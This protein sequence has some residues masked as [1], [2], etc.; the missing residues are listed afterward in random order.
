[1]NVQRSLLPGCI[2]VTYMYF[3][4]MDFFPSNTQENSSQLIEES[5]PYLLFEK[6]ATYFDRDYVPERAHRLLRDAKLVSII[7]SPAKRAYS[8]YQH[9]IAH[10]DPT[11]SKHS[12]YEIITAKP[13][14]PKNIRNLQA[15]YVNQTVPYFDS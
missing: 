5:S 9:M 11:A 4:Y 12:F 14:A 3:R 1:M 6:S 2:I 8:W 13:D 10:Q 7:I 15:R